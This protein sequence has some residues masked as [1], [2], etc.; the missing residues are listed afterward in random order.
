MPCP[1]GGADRPAK[2]PRLA[3]PVETPP[4]PQVPQTLRAFGSQGRSTGLEVRR[5]FKFLSS[6]FKLLFPQPGRRQ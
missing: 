1:V 3:V 5:P 4:R 6:P 2:R